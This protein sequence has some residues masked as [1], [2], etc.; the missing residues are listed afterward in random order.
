MMIS[1]SGSFL[2]HP[3]ERQLAYI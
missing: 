2:G 1:D 3:V